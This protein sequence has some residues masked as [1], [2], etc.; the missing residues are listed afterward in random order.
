MEKAETN[1]NNHEAMLKFLKETEFIEEIVIDLEK[2]DI[3]NVLLE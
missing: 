2:M 3:N 1:D